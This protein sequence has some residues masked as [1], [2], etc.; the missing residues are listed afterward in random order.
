MEFLERL[1]GQ[2]EIDAAL[3]T[4]DAAMQETLRRQ[5]GLLWK[6]KNVKAHVR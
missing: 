4:D 5:P 6:A 3:L 1:N 2:G